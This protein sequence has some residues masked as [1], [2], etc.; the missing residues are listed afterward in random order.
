ME[1]IFILVI[2]SMQTKKN[3]TFPKMNLGEQILHPS[4]ATHY[5]DK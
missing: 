1:N 4:I 5:T 2:L 3:R